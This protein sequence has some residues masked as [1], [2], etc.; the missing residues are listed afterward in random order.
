[1][2]SVRCTLNRGPDASVRY[3][4]RASA[5]ESRGQFDLFFQELSDIN[6]KPIEVWISAESLPS[7]EHLT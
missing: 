4:H 7:A 3:S 2:K 6:E 1:M 5:W